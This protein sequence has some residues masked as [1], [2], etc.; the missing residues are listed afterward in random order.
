MFGANIRCIVPQIA[1]SAGTMIACSSQR[2]VMTKHSNLG[3]IDPHLDGL[4]AAGVLR[5]FKQACD[6]VTDD[7]SKT[8][9]W[10]S[11]IGQYP[12]TFLGQCKNAIDWSSTFVRNE[13]RTVMFAGRPDASKRANKAVAFLSSD[14]INKTHS[15]H[16]HYDD[17]KDRLTV[18]LLE[19]STDPDFRISY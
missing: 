15:R 10:Q 19:D 1:M 13:L 12:P 5:E 16:L 2:I 7:P 3:P 11:I 18:D 4:P 17:L 14:T 6:E 9:I 8:K